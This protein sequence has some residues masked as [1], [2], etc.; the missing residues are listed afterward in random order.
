MS[1]YQMKEFLNLSAEINYQLDARVGSLENVLVTVLGDRTQS[2][3]DQSVLLATLEYLERAYE[4]KERR[5]GPRAILH[6]LRATASWFG[7]G[8]STP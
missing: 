7:R 6:P 4:K 5:L 2:E 3:A 8:R 1:L